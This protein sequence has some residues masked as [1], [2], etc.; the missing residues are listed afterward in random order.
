MK[1]ISQ[2]LWIVVA[3]V[4]VVVVALVVI[5]IFGGGISRFSTLVEAKS[6]CTMLGSPVC[7][8]G[9][10]APISWA[11]QNIKVGDIMTSCSADDVCKGW[12]IACPAPAAGVARTFKCGG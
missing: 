11:D 12:T 3:A 8:L 2:T 4:V 9:G 6:Y 1:G 7:A 10:A 5:T